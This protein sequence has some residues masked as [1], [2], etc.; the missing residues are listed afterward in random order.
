MRVALYNPD[1]PQN[2]AAVARLAACF[3]VALDLVEPFGF[4]WDERKLRRV[5]MDYLDRVEIV[6]HAGWAAFRDATRG[7]RL[8]LMTTKGA[9][10]LP[11]F[12]FRPGDVLLFGRESAGVPD[13]VHD[14]ADARVAI[15]I[16]AETRS[17]NLA[18]SAAV[19]VG[20]ALR[21]TGGYPAFQAK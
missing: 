12:A 20:E 5:G 17:L 7:A 11:S 13:A 16:R 14:A 21:Q 15:P 1:I 4:V 2:V 10:P 8:V 18:M 3:G 9:T 19:A 6:R